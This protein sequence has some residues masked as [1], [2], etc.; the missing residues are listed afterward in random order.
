VAKNRSNSGRGKGS[1]KP[2]DPEESGGAGSTQPS[3]APDQDKASERKRKSTRE[4]QKEKK[5]VPAKPDETP[6]TDGSAKP[7]DA[8]KELPTPVTPTSTGT[9][10][11]SK[12]TPSKPATS[13]SAA[14][15]PPTEKPVP[16]AKKITEYVVS[17]D[18]ATGAVV[19][20]EQVDPKTGQR[21][22]LTQEQYAG[23]SSVTNT[24]V[25]YF[26]VPAATPTNRVFTPP[27]KVIFGLP[28]LPRNFAAPA[29]TPVTPSFAETPVAPH[30]DA[31]M[32][33]YF[34][35]IMDYFKALTGT[36]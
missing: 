21:R 15:L 32:K 19:K 29:A 33:A 2:T 23:A 18:D 34:K 13:L 9:P 6:A 31:V 36:R 26:A 3:E 35:G 28:I 4:R 1:P 30:S 14:S 22:E 27:W 10:T 8:P 5:P 24:G 12:P 16:Q 11:A 25:P 17:I 7:S 20:I